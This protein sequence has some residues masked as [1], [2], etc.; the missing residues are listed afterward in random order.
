MKLD[1]DVLKKQNRL[2]L[3]ILLFSLL[4][5]LGAEVVVGAPVENMLAL[6]IG[7]IVGIGVIAFLNVKAMYSQ[8]VPYIAVVCLTGVSLIIMLSSDYVTNMLFTFFLLAVAAVSL[9]KAVLTTGGALGIGLLI[10]FILIKGQT[11]GFDTRSAAITTVFFILIFLVLFIQ[12]KVTRGFIATMHQTLSDM[13][14]KTNEEQIRTKNVQ[15]GAKKVREQMTIIEQDSNLNRNQIKEML[16][17]FQ[18]IARASQA[19]AET[20]A[21]ISESTNTTHQSLEKMLESFTRSIQDGE[22]LIGL[23]TKGKGTMEALS[24]T[25]ENFQL[26]F[27]TLTMNMESLVNRIYENNTNAEKIQAIAE[28]TNLLALNAS[29]EAARAGEYGKG[30][31]VVASEIRKL[32]EVSQLTAKQI[33]ENLQMIEADAQ[34]TQ[35]EVIYN[36]DQLQTS[37]GHALLA[38]ENFT[39]IIEQLEGFI[40]YLQYLNKQASTIKGSSE[41]IEQSVDN[42]ASLMEETTATIEELE[43]IVDEQVNRMEYLVVAVETT[44]E[45]AATLERS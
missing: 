13:E 12:I 43:A 18:E 26:S 8:L 20:A 24:G 15:A 30:F 21:G 17:G 11:V 22:D 7:G 14:L 29:I 35:K 10:F 33:R 34:S 2:L 41:S 38:T 28:Q 5:G 42:L 31:S 40:N 4:L 16:E 6:S 23:S 25:L 39:T 9:S 36:Q 3:Y 1:S 45:A 44:N 37:A 32:A 19:Q 27:Q